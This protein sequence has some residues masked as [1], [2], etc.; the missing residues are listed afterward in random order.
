[1]RL[2]D[3]VPSEEGRCEDSRIGYPVDNCEKG[4]KGGRS[5]RREGTEHEYMAQMNQVFIMRG[6]VGLELDQGLTGY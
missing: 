5:C 2:I 6:R 4:S 3:Y 1:M